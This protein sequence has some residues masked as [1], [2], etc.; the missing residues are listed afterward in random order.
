[1]LR[2]ALRKQRGYA[3][4]FQWPNR[5]VE[6]LGVL[7]ELIRCLSTSGHPIPDQIALRGRGFDPPDCEA[8]ASNGDRIAVE[9]TELVDQ[10]H[11]ELIKAPKKNTGAGYSDALFCGAEW[12]KE[13]FVRELSKRL[14]KKSRT[15]DSLKDGP[16]PGGYWVVIYTDEPNLTQSLAS[17]YLANEEFF[18]SPFLTRAFFLM[19]YDPMISAYPF[20]ELNLVKSVA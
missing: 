10:N 20:F 7:R 17:E 12:T 16:Y 2:D 9:I 3:D 13:K 19:S 8:T 18:V 1:L 4:F 15:F 14:P 5:D 11:I 6:E